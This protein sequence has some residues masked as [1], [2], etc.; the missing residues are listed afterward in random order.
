MR[1]TITVR[2]CTRNLGP[3]C[4]SV[5]VCFYEYQQDN[6]VYQTQIVSHCDAWE[7]GQYLDLQLGA[8][9]GADLERGGELHGRFSFRVHVAGGMTVTRPCCRADNHM[10]RPTRQRWTHHHTPIPSMAIHERTLAM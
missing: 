10:D 8:R 4:M 3:G 5:S 9:S 7:G 1:G 2:E 6:T